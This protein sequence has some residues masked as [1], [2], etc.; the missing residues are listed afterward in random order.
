MPT[1]DRPVPAPAPVRSTSGFRP[2]APR[3]QIPSPSASSV[4]SISD[5]QIADLFFHETLLP[6][7]AAHLGGSD[8]FRRFVSV[9]G[10]MSFVVPTLADLERCRHEWEIAAA[11][12][13]HSAKRLTDDQLRRFA[14]AR[15][16]EQWMRI[17][18]VAKRVESLLAGGEA[19]EGPEPA[20]SD[21]P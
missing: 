1:S 10:G 21:R 15:G 20:A 6:E 19:N 12:R 4:A 9:F 13:A 18:A 2:T 3:V 16:V 14:S 7:V 5:E 8:E 17:F 11:V